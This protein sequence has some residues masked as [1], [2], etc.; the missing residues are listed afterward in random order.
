MRL[1]KE[2]EMPPRVV[3][4]NVKERIES[5][6]PA[7]FFERVEVAGSGFINIWIADDAVRKEFI[8]IVKAGN[9][10]GHSNVGKGKKVIVEYSQ[11]NIAK[12]LHTGHLRNTILGDALANVHH[13]QSYE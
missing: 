7:G 1:A 8:K 13:A 12:E 3:A 4:E 11:P 5:A 6:A 10:Y 9:L 2:A